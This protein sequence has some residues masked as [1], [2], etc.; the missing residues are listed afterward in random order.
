[1]ETTEELTESEEDLDIESILKELDRNGI[2]WQPYLEN[3][4]GSIVLLE[5]GKLSILNGRW[6]VEQNHDGMIC[7]S[8]EFEKAVMACTYLT[9]GEWG[10]FIVG[11][12]LHFNNMPVIVCERPLIL[13]QTR[14][15]VDFEISDEAVDEFAKTDEFVEVYGNN[16]LRKIGWVH[17]HA[18]MGVFWSTTDTTTIKELVNEH[19]MEFIV[20]LVVGRDKANQTLKK[21]YRID[22]LTRFFGGKIQPY[23]DDVSEGDFV[24]YEEGIKTYEE[25]GEETRKKYQKI[26]DDTYVIEKTQ[27]TTV[28]YGGQR[29]YYD[30]RT[31]TMW[32]DDVWDSWGQ[33]FRRG[34]VNKKQRYK[35]SLT[36]PE[37][38]TQTT[39]NSTLV[40]TLLSEKQKWKMK[41]VV[42]ALPVDKLIQIVKFFT[43][44]PVRCRYYIL[45]YHN[46]KDVTMNFLN[47][48]INRTHQDEKLF[49]GINLACKATWPQDVRKALEYKL[50]GT[51]QTT[52][53]KSQTT[54]GTEPTPDW[55]E[56]FDILDEKTRIKLLSIFFQKAK[57]AGLAGLGERFIASGVNYLVRNEEKDYVD[58]FVAVYKSFKEKEMKLE[59]DEQIVFNDALQAILGEAFETY[60][61]KSNKDALQ[62][63]VNG[64]PEKLVIPFMKDFIADFE[65]EEQLKELF[66]AGKISVYRKRYQC[67][68]CDNWWDKKKD[69]KLCEK[70]CEKL[71][72][73][74]KTI[75][76]E[77]QTKE[78]T[79]T[80][81]QSSSKKVGDGLICSK[82]D[83][84]SIRVYQKADIISDDNLICGMSEAYWMSPF[85]CN[86]CG[87]PYSRIAEANACEEVCKRE[88]ILLT[89]DVLD[90]IGYKCPCCK[91]LLEDWKAVTQHDS[92]CIQYGAYLY[93]KLLSY[94]EPLTLVQDYSIDLMFLSVVA[95]YEDMKKKLPSVLLWV[96]LQRANDD[97]IDICNYCGMDFGN[98]LTDFVDNVFECYVHSKTCAPAKTSMQWTAV[99]DLNFKKTL[100]DGLY[101]CSLCD[102]RFGGSESEIL[103]QHLMF[104]HQTD[105]ELKAVQLLMDEAWSV[106]KQETKSL[107][108]QMSKPV[109]VLYMTPEVATAY[110][111]WMDEKLSLVSPFNACRYCNKTF[112]VYGKGENNVRACYKHELECK[113]SV[114]EVDDVD[115]LT[116]LY[117][118]TTHP[119]VVSRTICEDECDSQIRAGIY[120]GDW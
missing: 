70:Q 32:D 20:S 61:T 75:A 82:T 24:V 48:L 59:K 26:L 102:Y 120:K 100:D 1:M 64:L 4:D 74:K 115:N 35:R 58:Y 97:Y 84:G 110:N 14:S 28:Y 83:D 51:V 36:I 93:L 67:S 10:G 45:N 40:T 108:D 105:M 49:S 118:R 8:S 78:E 65:K 29:V 15:G 37:F 85:V 116:C 119:D 18:D 30:H 80:Q 52:L 60:F 81:M 16:E 44:T 111:T 43:V 53:Q 87:S 98:L 109:D 89:K 91:K 63:V 69:V 13:A 73:G 25:I 17:S 117:C 107:Q 55:N 72:A 21:K 113:I 46:F 22:R 42:N 95:D 71:R 86:Y 19:N 54:A 103:K 57:G 114:D 38:I 56:I 41:D 66:D 39:N 3:E 5:D 92:E 34:W 27:A 2:D 33:D 79:M 12:I 31:G 9:E 62:L 96:K 68:I 99:T 90:V 94:I 104:G 77:S 47:N 76:L 50:E 11:R 6:I 112:E 106:E 7:V 23:M 88:V 101:W